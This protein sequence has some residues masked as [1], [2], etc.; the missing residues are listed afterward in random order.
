MLRHRSCVLPSHTAGKNQCGKPQQLKHSHPL[1]CLSRKSQSPENNSSREIGFL[2]PHQGWL[3]LIPL[4]A[5]H[6][7]TTAW[8]LL[9]KPTYLA[10]LAG[11]S[12]QG[13][14]LWGPFLSLPCQGTPQTTT[15]CPRHLPHL[16]TMCQ[17]LPLLLM[18]FPPTRTPHLPEAPTLP[19]PTFHT[20][21]LPQVHTDLVLMYF[22]LKTKQDK[23]PQTFKKTTKPT[24]HTQQ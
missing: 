7:Q 22:H 13:A 9:S 5:L 14:G 11:S 23:K 15:V 2:H 20:T 21:S 3:Q 24:N 1:P 16:Q 12:G 10:M 8:R 4:L 18:Q 17:G 19:Q 6:G